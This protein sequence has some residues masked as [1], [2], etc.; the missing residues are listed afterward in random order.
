[1]IKVSRRRGY[2]MSLML[3]VLLII[4]GTTVTMVRTAFD[5]QSASRTAA[6]RA[7][8]RLYASAALEEFF[9]RVSTD[10]GFLRDVLAFDGIKVPPH[11]ALR[12]SAPSTQ[13]EGRWALLS[14]P[15]GWR[16]G[17][18]AVPTG[19]LSCP[20][21]DAAYVS[22][23]YYLRVL[24]D[25]GS[26]SQALPP[27]VVVEVTL[28]TR[29][30]G[31]PDRC[32]YTRFQQRLRR[33]QFFEFA[34]AQELST[35][36]PEALF[37]A[38]SFDVGG[39]NRDAFLKY[40]SAC[41]NRRGL[42]RAGVVLDLDVTLGRTSSD[43]GFFVPDGADLSVEGCV[44]MAYQS[45]AATT[46]TDKLVGPVYTAD[47]FVTVC[48]SPEL[49]SV[50]VSGRGWDNDGNGTREA[51]RGSPSASCA[52]SS[53]S[54]RQETRV[55]M[56]L[57]PPSLDVLSD[58]EAAD[59]AEVLEK[60]DPNRP[61]VAVFAGDSVTF[62]N[63]V[64]RSGS[65]CRMSAV[66]GI[67]CPVDGKVLVVRNPSASLGSDYASVDLHV[68]GDV[69]GKVSLVVDGS[70]AIVD[71]LVYEPAA[72]F[73]ALRSNT[74]DVLTLTATE[75][76]EIWQSCGPDPSP[77]Y[78]NCTTEHEDRTVH[79]VLTSGLGYIGVPDWQYNTENGRTQKTLTF[80]GSIASRYQGVYGAYVE[81][82]VTDRRLV[83]GFYKNFSHDDLS[84][85][86]DSDDPT[87]DSVEEQLP[88]FVETE[89]AVWTR[90]DVTEVPYRP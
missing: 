12:A 43:S 2:A 87:R 50:F 3:L 77:R 70:V 69:D 73:P 67:E 47:D 40:R 28:R 38:G 80:F 86:I 34:L 14:M 35:L 23:C 84:R 58:A 29:C 82:G 26:D 83:S 7:Q 9:A 19:S 88:F 60:V 71:D 10:E 59:G 64:L 54:A 49:S 90:V 53:L 8:A 45:D 65:E 1:M 16:E 66:G 48:G 72:S 36:A 11:P 25:A 89:T 33:T 13:D 76:I 5:N 20:T 62:T 81:A 21:G 18:K 75:R 24:A 68:S 85:I 39:V 41:G 51:Y 63:A 56:L 17:Q 30:A 52:G 74:S 32:I 57:Q 15:S 61:V 37:P 55:P 44:D 22:D 4:T 6:A 42:V 46:A 31:D 27:V 79:G 78:D